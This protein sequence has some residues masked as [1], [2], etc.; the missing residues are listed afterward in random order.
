[1]SDIIKLYNPSNAAS[2]T[3]DQTE[4]LQRLNSGEIKELA[5]AYPNLTMQRAYLLIVDTKKP[6][7]KQLPTLS[8]FENLWNLREKN[9]LRN[10]VAFGFRGTY[11]PKTLQPVKAKR[12]EIL[13][14]SET[15]LMNLPGFKQNGSQSAT[16]KQIDVAEMNKE[17]VKQADEVFKNAEA[18]TQTVKVKKVR[19]QKIK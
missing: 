13:D 6:I 16:A 15:E 12:T 18:A 7:D 10:Y 9:G 19:K 17:V 11:K 2:L 1:M 5:K 4:G 8:T 3:T 14:L